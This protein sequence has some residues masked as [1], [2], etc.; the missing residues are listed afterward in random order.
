MDIEN[1][2]GD[3]G[4]H[5]MGYGDCKQ[6]CWKLWEDEDNCLRIDIFKKK[7]KDE[8]VFVTKGKTHT[9]FGFRKFNLLIKKIVLYI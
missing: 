2:F 5:D 9:L 7:I 3:I 1:I 4:G 6:L 8:N